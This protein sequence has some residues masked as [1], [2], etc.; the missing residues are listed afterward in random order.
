MRVAYVL[1][2]K[3]HA[4]AVASEN[5]ILVARGVQGAPSSITAYR[6]D[7]TIDPG[8]GENGSAALHPEAR[9]V[10]AMHVEPDGQILVGL[11]EVPR[12]QRLNP[13]GSPDMTFGAGGTL[14]IGFAGANT[15]LTDVLLQPD[16]RV[17]VAGTPFSEVEPEKLLHLKR[18]LANGAPDP[19]IGTAGELQLSTGNPYAHDVKLSLQPGGQIV[20]VVRSFRERPVRVARLSPGGALDPSFGSGGLADAE[21]ADQRRARRATTGSR[22]DWRPLTLPDGRIRIPVMLDVPRERP[23]RMALVGLGAD[24]H[25]DRSFGR[26]GLAVAPRPELPGG[27]EPETAIADERGGILVAGSLWSGAELTGDEVGLIRRFRADGTPDRSFGRLGVARGAVP[28]GGYSVI[29]QRLALLDADTL[30]AAEHNYDGKYGFWGPAAVRT[31]NAGYDD[32]GPLI[33]I[34]RG[35][36]TVVVRIRDLSRLERVVVRADGRVVRRTTRKRFRVRLPAGSR[37]VS[38]R[39]IDLAGLLGASSRRL[40]C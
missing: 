7:G 32:S 15:L 18:Y 29:E 22:G 35:C 17:L 24:G 14:D 11:K 27:E 36:R 40:R 6:P 1:G 31:L 38:V 13:D 33:L 9:E 25:P 21:F 4:I 2:E 39:A 12:L 23:Y 26:R 28:G 30:I 3:I 20:L 10:A 34:R 19:T 16:G 37:R 5:R 8:F